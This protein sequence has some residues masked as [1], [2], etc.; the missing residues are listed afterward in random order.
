MRTRRIPRDCECLVTNAFI[1]TYCFFL[2]HY[3][4]M[5]NGRNSLNLY[6]SLCRRKD[7][8]GEGTSSAGN[9]T[10][11]KWMDVN[12][13]NTKSDINMDDL[14]RKPAV[15]KAERHQARFVAFEPAESFTDESEPERASL[16][17]ASWFSGDLSADDLD[18]L[19]VDSIESELEIIGP[20]HVNTESDDTLEKILAMDECFHYESAVPIE[21]AENSAASSGRGASRAGDSRGD[22]LDEQ[23]VVDSIESK[24]EIIGPAHVDAAEDLWTPAEDKLLVDYIQANGH[25]SWTMLPKLAGQ[26]SESNLPRLALSNLRL[27]QPHLTPCTFARMQG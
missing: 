12:V 2:L 24:R 26:D 27:V 7:T 23:E 16:G 14:L 1:G 17:G 19:E 21:P 11:R 25:G 10:V 13:V 3:F 18:E 9:R 6:Y 20:A 22:D 15:P 8:D 4:I 5:P